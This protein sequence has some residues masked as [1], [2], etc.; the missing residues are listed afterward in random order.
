[1]S[2]IVH[3]L[4]RFDVINGI[5]AGWWSSHLHVVDNVERT[6]TP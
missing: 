5:A 2:F 3:T 4:S 1:M 6:K